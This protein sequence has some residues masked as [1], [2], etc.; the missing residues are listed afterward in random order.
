M[1]EELDS[2]M[3]QTVGHNAIHA[4][5]ECMQVPLYQGDLGGIAHQKSLEYN[6]EES[7]LSDEVEDLKNLLQRVK[8]C[9]ELL[10]HC[11]INMEGA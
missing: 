3:F 11:S 8:V 2:W 7:E 6:E 5:A 10:Q 1:E 9:S 4:I